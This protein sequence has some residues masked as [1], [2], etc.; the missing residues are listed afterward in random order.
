MA[1]KMPSPW[2]HPKTSVYWVRRRVPQALRDKLGT[3]L[4]QRTLETK[5]PTEAKIR[6]ADALAE[7]NE[8]WARLAAEAGRMTRKQRQAL[9]GE[10]CRWSVARREEDPGRPEDMRRS[11]ERDEARIKPSGGRISSPGSVVG[12][13]LGAFLVE[14]GIAVHDLD[15]F[16]LSIDCAKAEVIAKKA[17]LRNAMGDYGKAFDLDAFPKYVPSEEKAGKIRAGT[18]VLS[19]DG[20]WDAFVSERKLSIATQKRWRPLLTKFQSHFGRPDLSTALPIEIGEWKRDLLSSGLSH[21][22]VRE[23]HIAALRSFYGWAIDEGKMAINPAS[24]IKVAR[25]KVYESEPTRGNRDIGDAHARLILSETLRL[26]DPQTPAKLAAAKR[27]VPWICAYT[28]ARVNEVTQLRSQDIVLERVG[29]DEVLIMRITPDAGT[30][31]GNRARDVVLHPHLAEQGLAEFVRS[32]GGGPLFYERER[33]RKGSEQN[34]PFRKVGERIARWVRELGVDDPNVDP[35]HGWRHRFKTTARN[36]KMDHEVREGMAG[37]ATKTVGEGYG[38][39]SREFLWTEVRKLPRYEVAAPVG[40]PPDTPA[41]RARSAKRVATAER[42]RS[43]LATKT[44]GV[45]GSAFPANDGAV[46]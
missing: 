8:R 6:F 17:L 41:R 7:L 39:L 25:E 5:D 33:P 35:N 38:G 19:V 3:A 16:D 24:G 9:A 1:V 20:D 23:G 42:R 40:A 15:M 11:I 31:K 13:L 34:Q 14:R 4:Y 12:E 26:P 43:L 28:G 36:V 2:K 29:G 46:A 10:Y 37:H 32:S 18:P 30:V 21:K 44:A 27:W 45:A 22:T